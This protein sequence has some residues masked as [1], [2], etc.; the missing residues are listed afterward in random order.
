M[1][2]AKKD[3]FAFAL[4]TSIFEAVAEQVSEQEA[5]AVE[6]AE[7]A[8]KSMSF[9]DMFEAAEHTQ[10]AAEATGAPAGIRIGVS[11]EPGL[12]LILRIGNDDDKSLR[13]LLEDASVPKRVHDLKGTLRDA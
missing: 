5:E 12:A 7:P 4:E 11:A 6:E 1:R 8:L 9:M 13:A 2:V 3:G 10:T